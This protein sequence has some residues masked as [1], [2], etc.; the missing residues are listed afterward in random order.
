M[1]SL[2]PPPAGGTVRR[3]AP[4]PAFLPSPPAGLGRVCPPLPP[5]RTAGACVSRAR[6]GATAGAG[7]GER[8]AS[9]DVPPRAAA[10]G[11]MQAAAVGGWVLVGGG[12]AVCRGVV[13]RGAGGGRGATAVGRAAAARARGGAGQV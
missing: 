9:P 12:G 1:T 5:P 7:A 4:S 3:A 11:T 10:S 2:V 8:A 13:C 6:P